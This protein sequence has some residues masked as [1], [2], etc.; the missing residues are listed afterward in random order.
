MRRLPRRTRLAAA[1]TLALALPAAPALALDLL[2]SYQ[3]ATRNDG[4]L[5]AARARADADK[6]ALPQA[7]GQLLPNV[8]ASYSRGDI[9]QDTKRNNLPSPTIN[10][11]SEQKSLTISQPIY[12]KYQFSQLGEARAKVAGAEARLSASAQDMGTRVVSAYF[13]A[14]FQRD[15]LALIQAQQASVGAQLKSARL[16]FESGTGT[17]TD[18]DEAQAK[19]DV[20]AADEI[21]AR[22]AI[23]SSA[24]QLAIFIGAPVDGLA[25]IDTDKLELGGFEPGE[26]DDWL[27]QALANSPDIRT[28]R[29]RVEQT[30]AEIS[31][32]RA[33]HHPTVDGVVRFSNSLSESPQVVGSE[34]TTRYVGVQVQVPIFA[35]GQVNSQVRAAVASNQEA[36]ESL[37]FT[38]NDVQLKVRKEYADIREGLTRVRALET[39]VRSADQVVLSNRK[40]VEAGTRTTLDVLN[41]EQQRFNTRLELARA[42]YS[43]LVSWAQLTGLAGT[44][45]EA[46]VTRINAAL[47]STAAH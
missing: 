12:R 40:G 10:Y 15:R 42:R 9:E 21:Q 47:S 29:A 45:N 33:G 31:M 46:E 2:E 23:G 22:Q 16:A 14:L 27:Q 28:L 36:K 34:F 4:Q 38:I 43:L 24:Q 13:D 25:V 19:L 17:R 30:D 6:E 20:L 26:L 41:V 8:S 1:L 18:I 39:A 44:L 3:L 37:A 11:V 7:I 32:A 5:K 35:G